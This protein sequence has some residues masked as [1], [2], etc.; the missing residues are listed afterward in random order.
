MQLLNEPAGP[1][2]PFRYADANSHLLGM[3]AEHMGGEHLEAL[4]K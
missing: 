1:P 4:Y 2:G 3:L